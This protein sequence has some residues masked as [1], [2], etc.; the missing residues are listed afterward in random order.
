M[1]L[2]RA[3]VALVV[4][5]AL[6]AATVR[7]QQ[8]AAPPAAAAPAGAPPAGAPPADGAPPPGYAPAPYGAPYGGAPYG[9][10][11]YGA[12]VYA[13]YCASPYGAMP[14]GS[15]NAMQLMT[16]ESQK[17]SAPLALVLSLFLFPGIGSIYADHP[18]GAFI[19]WAGIAG[20]VVLIVFGVRSLSDAQNANGVTTDQSAQ[21][22]GASLLVAGFFTIVGFSIY[23]LV[24]A[25]QSANNYN[26][27]LAQR[28]G[29]P[30]MFT[31]A[32][33]PIAT[34]RS[35]AWGPSLQLR[36]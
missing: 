23:S 11:P 27:A 20:G 26:A 22:R 35:V 9:G 3:S 16:F 17:K 29:L 12:P 21:D 1:R 28:L 2:A 25:W 34:S 10:A 5:L 24:D 6:P 19:T 30:P 4:S 13:P 14:Y 18:Q 33:A 32:P 36:F 7:A 15:P 31:I 8:P